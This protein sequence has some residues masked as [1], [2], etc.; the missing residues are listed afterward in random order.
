[1]L[2]LLISGIIYWLNKPLRYHIVE[3]QDFSP[4]LDTLYNDSTDG[5]ILV[6]K[7]K[8]SKKFIQFALYEKQGQQRNLHFGFP[9]TEWSRKFFTRMQDVFDQNNIHYS[10]KKTGDYP[11]TQFL[12][13]N[14]IQNVEM[15]MNIVKLALLALNLPEKGKYIVH[16]HAHSNDEA[17]ERTKA[18]FAEL[19]QKNK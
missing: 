10:L 2:L 14:F 19:K 6:L 7:H 5:G 18:E 9:D 4:F 11:T 13:I 16:I 8:K 17:I 12:H 1:M 15:A 3:I